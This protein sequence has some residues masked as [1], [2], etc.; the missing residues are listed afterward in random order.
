[1]D[2]T[3][4][5]GKLTEALVAANMTGSA[6]PYQMAATTIRRTVHV[7]LR[8]LP[9]WDPAADLAIEEAVRGGLQALILADLDVARGGFLTLGELTELAEEFGRDP[10]ET[11]MS[12][13]RGMAAVQGLIPND[14][15]HRLC[16][17]IEASYVGGG[18]ALADLLRAGASPPNASPYAA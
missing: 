1:M 4:R 6:D 12:A 11:M 15:L 17:A 3:Y 5:V 18:E 9:A 2:N 8:A 14:Q 16:G 7:A 13:L 10:S